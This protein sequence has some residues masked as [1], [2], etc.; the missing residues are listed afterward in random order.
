MKYVDL[1][2]F[3]TSSLRFSPSFYGFDR[4]FT[5]KEISITSKPTVKA[6][7]LEGNADMLLKYYR[8]FD[9]LHIPSY[10]YSLELF[11][12]AKEQDKVFLVSISQILSNPL[13][14]Y[15]VKNFIKIARHY[16]LNIIFA[17]LATDE[18]LIRSVEE[19][20]SILSYCGLTR[21]QV[22]YGYSLLEKY[23]KPE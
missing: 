13:L 22:R 5:T 11:A 18:Y 10:E 6:R 9:I 3:D 7:I 14:I 17:S 1:V 2:D 8:K 21:D 20:A 4:I 19:A 16:D 23:V 15:R 12:K